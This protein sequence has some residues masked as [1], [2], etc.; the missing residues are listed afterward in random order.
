M[1][2]GGA[3][4]VMEWAHVAPVRRAQIESL[5]SEALILIDEAQQMFAHAQVMNAGGYDP[6]FTVA[7]MSEV[8]LTTA[9]LT[10][11]QAWLLHRRA[12]IAEDPSARGD[13]RA[14]VLDGVTPADWAICH[15]MPEA[16]RRIVAASERLME[17]LHVMDSMW[18]ETPMASPHVVPVHEMMD[19][20]RARL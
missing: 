13:D 16:M 10:H 9:R 2:N 5:Y 6:E 1:W 7:V 17:R 4:P 20:L 3:N 18:R 15:Y 8:M 12:M 11:V 14:V 19:M